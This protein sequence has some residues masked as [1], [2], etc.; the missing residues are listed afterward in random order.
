MSPWPASTTPRML[1]IRADRVAQSQ[2]QVEARPLPWQPSEFAAE[3]F[4][5]DSFAVARRR[6]CD[7]GVGMHMV[8]VRERQ[9]RMKRSIDA[10]GAGA[11]GKGA[12]VEVRRRSRLRAR[13][14]GSGFPARRVCLDTVFA[15]PDRS[16]EPRSSPDPFTH[17]IVTRSLLSGSTSAIFADVLPPP[18][19]VTREIG[20]QQMGAVQKQLGLGQRLR[21]GVVPSVAYHARIVTR[22]HGNS[23]E[24][25][26]L[27]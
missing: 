4:A 7:D 9:K 24:Q 12:I 27:D 6:N 13:V 21:V 14:R 18:K 22:R 26:R 10:G 5:R 3:H 16:I 11:A 23:I 17:K 15:K 19:L 1:R 8:D 20:A 25:C 2:A